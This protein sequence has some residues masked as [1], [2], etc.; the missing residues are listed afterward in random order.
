LHDL[1]IADKNNEKNE[2]VDDKNEIL[3]FLL[4]DNEKEE[5]VKKD[6]KDNKHDA[7]AF[8]LGLAQNIDDTTDENEEILWATSENDVKYQNNDENIWGLT[9]PQDRAS[10]MRGLK[11]EEKNS[12][13]EEE[14][15]KND[16][17]KSADTKLNYSLNTNLWNNDAS[18]WNVIEK[19]EKRYEKPYENKINE[20]MTFEY[21]QKEN[22][23]V[24]TPNQQIKQPTA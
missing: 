8:E 10:L 3:N 17:D 11:D 22:K 19:E 4:N 18:R 15:I 12:K 13:K 6:E 20:E 5:T 23:T 7:I 1:G 9:L 21:V 14:V 2:T 16:Y 24:N